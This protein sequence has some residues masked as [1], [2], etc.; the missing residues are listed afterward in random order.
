MSECL[1]FIAN[2]KASKK[3]GEKKV[4]NCRCRHRC[5][6]FCTRAGAAEVA[7]WTT[8][9]FPSAEEVG[10]PPYVA[11]T[12]LAGD[13]VLH[14]AEARGKGTQVGG[15]APSL[16]AGAGTGAG[17]GAGAGAGAGAGTGAGAGAGPGAGT[18]MDAAGP[19]GAGP[20]SGMCMQGRK[21]DWVSS[22]PFE[23]Q[24][25]AKQC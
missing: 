25:T 23:H 4:Q 10:A 19:G 11:P 6:F 13:P 20:M 17:T 2:N 12:E 8:A 14:D 7:E 21:E 1:V 16:G 15:F 5:L 3:L 22:T 9:A 18:V 24:R